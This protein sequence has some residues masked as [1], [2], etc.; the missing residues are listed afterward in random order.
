M[1]DDQTP[2]VHHSPRAQCRISALAFPVVDRR[3]PYRLQC[4]RAQ[5]G[6][7]ARHTPCW[8]TVT[9]EKGPWGQTTSAPT[10][11]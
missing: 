4:E 3:T 9:G 10:G 6:K 7:P 8:A 5:T 1:H 2:P 11:T